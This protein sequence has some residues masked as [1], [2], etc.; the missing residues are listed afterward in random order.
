[1]ATNVVTP[2]NAPE[3]QV[4]EQQKET[5]F[6]AK[7]FL[8]QRNA[9]EI[10]QRGGKPIPK[11]AEEQKP[12]EKPVAAALEKPEEHAK[13]GE[14][15]AKPPAAEAGKPAEADDDQAPQHRMSRSERRAMNRLREELGAERARREIAERE[16]AELRGKRPA[17]SVD[18][19]AKPAT[20]TSDELEPKESDFTTE[21]EYLRAVARY[22]GRQTAK[23]E[24]AKRETTEADAA[25][26]QRFF[27]YVQAM[28]AK[29]VEDRKLFPDWEEKI[30]EAHENDEELTWF[31]PNARDEQGNVHNEHAVFDGLIKTSDQ[32]TAILYYF[33]EHPKE[34]QKI[35]A[36]SSNPGEQ[37]R[38]FAQLEGKVE[39]LYGDRKPAAAPA[40]QAAAPPA[41]EAPKDRNQPADGDKPGRTAA[42]RDLGKP[43]PSSE[44]SAPGGSAA[45]SEPPIGSA[46][47]MARRNQA[48]YGR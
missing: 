11:P 15:E 1:M 24:L 43:K 5:P 42:E 40:A 19:L 4:A 13:P 22:E 21:G 44:V 28:D 45:P 27:E 30:E 26:Q 3:G 25:K 37:I 2:P 18:A 48:Q 6:D 16:A 23:A 34:F 9:A 8:E 17:S 31:E 32:R 33:T 38:R 20:A 35:L 29:A 7:A 39:G 36:L 46:A 10:A 14:P 41:K 12:A 47:W